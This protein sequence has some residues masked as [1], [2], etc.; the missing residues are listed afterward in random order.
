[1]SRGIKLSPKHGVNP[2]IPIC[3]WCGKQKNE[4]AFCGRIDREDSE[5]PKNLVLDY[6]PCDECKAVH[7]KG[8]LLIEAVD[9]IP[10]NGRPPISKDSEGRP[11]YPTGRHVVMKSDAF[12]RIFGC[13]TDAK[14]V[15]V[16]TEIM[17]NI[18]ESTKS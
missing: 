1:M 11:V 8:V 12:Q 13:A 7:S 5:A 9:S 2:C 14:K 6:E 10:D 18:L 15:C 17:D 3:F 4:I 16:D